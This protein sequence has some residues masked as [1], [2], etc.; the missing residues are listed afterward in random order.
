MNKLDEIKT[1]V[2]DLILSNKNMITP[3][4]NDKEK[5]YYVEYDK[6][7]RKLYDVFLKTIGDDDQEKTLGEFFINNDSLKKKLAERKKLAVNNSLNDAN[8]RS[9]LNSSIDF[10]LCI[11]TVLVNDVS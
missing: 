3:H 2:D 10:Y 1:R 9:E 11:E 6:N 5:E 4:I 8:T 7:I